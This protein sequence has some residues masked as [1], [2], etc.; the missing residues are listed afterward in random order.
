M[1]DSKS[2]TGLSWKVP[3]T[4]A[5]KYLSKNIE[6]IF[7]TFKISNEANIL[8]AGCGGG[9][10]LN[11][12]YNKGYKNIWGFDVSESGVN[13]GRNSYES[14]RDRF[15]LHNCYEKNLPAIFPRADY[16]VILSVEVI[17]HLYSPMSYLENI[18]LWLKKG[19]YLIITTPYHGYLKNLA[20]SLAGKFDNHVDP[21]FEGGHIKFFSKKTLYKLLHL[22]GFKPLRFYGSGR[23]P[24]LWKSMVIVAEKI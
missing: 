8:D 7:R 15:A 18:K 19:G 12:I 13:L 17:E 4:C 22:T 11:N 6:S 9:Y 5:H 3:Q 14:L 24:F 2:F 1:L 10:I 21:L 23:L 16:N 20:I